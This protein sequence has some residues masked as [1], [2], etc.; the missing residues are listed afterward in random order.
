MEGPG[1]LSLS[2]GH[3]NRQAEIAAGSH[4]SRPLLRYLFRLGRYV[5][6]LLSLR[7]FMYFLMK[8]IQRKHRHG[9]IRWGKA[10]SSRLSSA[11]LCPRL[12]DVRG[13][14][15]RGLNEKRHHRITTTG[16]LGLNGTCP[17]PLAKEREAALQ[18][19]CDEMS[20]AQIPARST[21][22]LRRGV[23]LPQEEAPQQRSV[24]PPR[25]AIDGAAA[26]RNEDV[27]G[28]TKPLSVN[29]ELEPVV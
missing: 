7:R 16:P 21:E 24:T 14:P 27:Y 17:L 13:S 6:T 23:S 5:F 18:V 3:R 4:P 10:N 15:L 25:R 28:L 2:F 22:P 11:I 12:L 19:R 9:L 29:L 8:A 1:W 20:R 26:Q